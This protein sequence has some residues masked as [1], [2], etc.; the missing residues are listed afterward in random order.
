MVQDKAIMLLMI[1]AG[2]YSPWEEH[3]R[4]ESVSVQAPAS[5]DNCLVDTLVSNEWGSPRG[6]PLVD[7]PKG[8]RTQI[9]GF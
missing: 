9:I 4:E 6:T 3:L 2:F 5:Q 7:D 8:P 1:H